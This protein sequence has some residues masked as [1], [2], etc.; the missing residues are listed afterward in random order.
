MKSVRNFEIKSALPFKKIPPRII[1]QQQTG[2]IK[3]GGF[4]RGDYLPNEV[5]P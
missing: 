4:Y 1:R 3:I 5:I 2:G